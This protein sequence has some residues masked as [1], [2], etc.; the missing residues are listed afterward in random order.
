MVTTLTEIGSELNRQADLVR[1]GVEPL[2]DE[3]QER[4]CEAFGKVRCP[5]PWDDPV[6]PFVS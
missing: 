6:S 4:A 2:G 5:A 3:A 1:D